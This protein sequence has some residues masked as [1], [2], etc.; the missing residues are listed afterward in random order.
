MTQTLL[1][2][3]PFCHLFDCGNLTEHLNQHLIKLFHFIFISLIVMKEKSSQEFILEN[4][5]P[6]M[7]EITLLLTLHYYLCT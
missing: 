4:R 5:L 7:R 6:Y 1:K 2:H 3:V